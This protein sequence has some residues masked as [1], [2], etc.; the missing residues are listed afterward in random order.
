M[1]DNWTNFGFKTS[2]IQ[3]DSIENKPI[4]NMWK[5]FV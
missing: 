2:S 1:K 3:Y 4:E 5:I